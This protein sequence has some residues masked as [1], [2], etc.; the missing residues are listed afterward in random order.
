M[1]LDTDVGIS[2]LTK[3]ASQSTMRVSSSSTTCW[4]ATIHASPGAWLEKMQWTRTCHVL[5]MKQWTSEQA[6]SAKNVHPIC[7]FPVANILVGTAKIL[8]CSTWQIVASQKGGL[9]RMCCTFLWGSWSFHRLLSR[10][11]DNLGNKGTRVMVHCITIQKNHPKSTSPTKQFSTIEVQID[12][13]LF[14]ASSAETQ[15]VIIN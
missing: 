12:L 3:L 11:C 6:R 10:R 4:S 13:V 5:C 15:H 8:S 14:T 7:V 9:R 1:F 2:L